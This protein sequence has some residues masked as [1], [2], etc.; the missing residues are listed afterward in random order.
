MLLDETLNFVR[1]CLFISAFFFRT[2]TRSLFI[3]VVA[4][5][6]YNQIYF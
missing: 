6:Q 3:N 1:R 4:H 5:E 2:L